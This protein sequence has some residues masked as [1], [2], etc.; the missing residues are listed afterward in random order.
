MS[1]PSTSSTGWQA[2]CRAAGLIAPDS[3]WAA[4]EEEIGAI[5]NGCG[6]DTFNGWPRW[7]LRRIFGEDLADMA[8][9]AMLTQFLRIFEPA[10]PPHD[11]EYN[12]SDHTEESWH[13]ANER[14]LHNMGVLLEAAYPF[15][16]VWAWP[17]R[18]RWYLR[19]RAAYRAV[20]SD[21]GYQAWLD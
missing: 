9:R 1:T 16:H 7:F 21:D 5:Y 10:F 8:G 11:W 14:M 19:M 13:A 12:Y 17:L 20:E 4:S 15:A 3:F 2:R 6:P 18:V